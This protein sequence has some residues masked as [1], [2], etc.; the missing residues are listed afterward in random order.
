MR[1]RFFLVACAVLFLGCSRGAGSPVID[2]DGRAV[3]PLAGAAAAT[4]LVFVST[5]CPISNRYAPE[6]R[7]L[8]A[9]FA[10]RGVEFR[11]VY[12]LAGESPSLI[13]DH[14]RDYAYPFPA[15]RDPEHALVA[16]AGVT[17]TP[18]VAVFRTGELIYRGR[19]DDR[20]VDFG[21]TRPAA[22]QHDLEDALENVLAG[23][24]VETK[25]TRTVGCAI[26]KAS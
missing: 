5:R 4:V 8:H 24:R 14:V 2:L 18:E 25:F 21:V 6:L 15:A 10:P 19:I 1:V 12:P 22:T 3:D 11:L 26:P 7:R 9:R 13:R 17:V 23:R 16:R 20:E